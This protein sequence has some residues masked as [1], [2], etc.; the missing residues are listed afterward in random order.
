MMPIEKPEEVK[1]L[2]FLICRKAQIFCHTWI[3]QVCKI[4]AFSPKKP[5]KRQIFFAYLEKTNMGVG[6]SWM[7]WRLN[8]WTIAALLEQMGW[9]L[10][11]Q[12]I[13]WMQQ[14]TPQDFFGSLYDKNLTKI[15]TTKLETHHYFLNFWH[16]KTP[17]DED[18]FSPG[19]HT[20]KK[21]LLWK[22]LDCLRFAI[23]H[24]FQS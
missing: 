5:T 9:G 21:Y 10:P 4:C 7:D 8:S 6:W 22:Y 14:E 18:I 23:F 15:K 17:P 20:E 2:K 11:K 13:G 1:N 12:W 19:K 3:F 16:P 24:L